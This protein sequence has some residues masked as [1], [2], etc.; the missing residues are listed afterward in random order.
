MVRGG[1]SPHGGRG[2]LHQA[3]FDFIY[4]DG[5]RSAHS[6]RGTPFDL[7]ELRRM[8]L[9][10]QPAS[11]RSPRQSNR[12]PEAGTRRRGETTMLT[13]TP[14]E[15]RKLAHRRH[16][17]HLHQAMAE[18]VLCWRAHFEEVPK[19]QA[20]RKE[21]LLALGT[22]GGGQTPRDSQQIAALPAILLEAPQMESLGLEIEAIHAELAAQVAA[23]PSR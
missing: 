19:D 9:R 23:A 10:T 18:L 4:L 5:D 6:K 14:E 20:A 22:L 16:A 17:H 2:T 7:N 11:G 21:I 1:G 12:N 8:P 13:P 3:E 15:S